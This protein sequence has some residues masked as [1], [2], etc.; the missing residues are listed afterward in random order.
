LFSVAEPDI[1]TP[2]VPLDVVM[3]PADV[4]VPVPALRVWAFVTA[5]LMVLP[6]GANCAQ[7]GVTSDGMTIAAAA[8]RSR[9]MKAGPSRQVALTRQRVR[10][11]N[12]RSEPVPATPDRWDS[13]IV[14]GYEPRVR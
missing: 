9:C 13:G 4:T 5:V 6:A 2:T 8:R 10:S 11:G 3:D 14:T 1:V 12:R 7:A